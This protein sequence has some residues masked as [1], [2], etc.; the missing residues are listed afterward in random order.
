MAASKYATKF[1]ATIINRSSIPIPCKYFNTGGCWKGNSCKF[2]H[3]QYQPLTQSQRPNST[4]FPSQHQPNNISKNVVPEIII[5]LTNLINDTFKQQQQQLN[6][7]M[8]KLIER[9]PQR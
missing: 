6:N 7:F 3:I 8:D 1:I 9:I 5:K 4:S 2:Q